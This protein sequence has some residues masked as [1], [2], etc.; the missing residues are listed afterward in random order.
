MIEGYVRKVIHVSY[1]FKEIK[2]MKFYCGVMCLKCVMWL[3]SNKIIISC[4]TISCV[5]TISDLYVI[6]NNLT[7]MDSQN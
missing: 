4:Y 6:V 2:T 1:P 3:K 7:R 5:C